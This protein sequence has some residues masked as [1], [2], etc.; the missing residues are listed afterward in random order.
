MTDS[1][2]DQWKQC[3]KEVYERADKIEMMSLDIIQSTDQQVDTW[4]LA[5]K[6]NQESHKIKH[7]IDTYISQQGNE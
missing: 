1:K 4:K 3:S 7:I 2:R 6:I 5:Y